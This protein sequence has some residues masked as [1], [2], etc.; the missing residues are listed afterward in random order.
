VFKGTVFSGND[1]RLGLLRSQLVGVG[2]KV[3][4]VFFPRIVGKKVHCAMIDNPRFCIKDFGWVLF[5]DLFFPKGLCY[6]LI[7]AMTN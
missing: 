6:V 4:R 3:P 2:K 5:H 7:C 1:R